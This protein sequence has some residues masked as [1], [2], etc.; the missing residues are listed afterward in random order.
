MSNLML[1]IVL[2]LVVVAIAQLTRIYEL[3]RK[4]KQQREEVISDANNKLN[5]NLWMVFMVAFYGMFIW[6]TIAYWDKMLPPSASEHGVTIDNLMT[7]NLVLVSAV[8]FV[9][10]TL[11]FWFCYK[12]Y[13]KPGRKA[14]FFPH[15]NRLE[16][17]WTV[18][19]TVVLAIIIITGLVAWD[20]ITDEASEDA[21]NIELYSK[22]FDWT[23]R[24]GGADNQLG[25]TSFNFISGTNPLGIITNESIDTK[26]AEIDEQIKANETRLEEEV[27][28]DAV[29]ESVRVATR[30]L[31]AQRARINGLKISDEQMKQGY[32]DRIVKAEFHLPVGKEVRFTFRSQDVIHSA[33]MPHFRAQMNTVPGMTTTFKFTPTITTDSMRTML[34]DE[35]FNYT[36]LCNKICGSA[37]YNMK[38]DIIVE[39]EE[40][41]K[42]WLE[43]QKT[44]AEA[45]GLNDQEEGLAENLKK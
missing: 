11:L 30:R 44:F 16:L 15:D 6:L 13:S 20:D 19:P 29:E 35:N 33:Y 34:G 39:S 26:L 7:L 9:V 32:D 17:F 43:G 18:V 37:H 5:A 38:M 24:Y 31:Y 22:Q 8:F 2:V 1:F 42:R 21:I 40:D 3:G 41:Y 4:L 23:A 45:Y 25:S 36:L 27:M 12:Y 14:V 10:N 28:S